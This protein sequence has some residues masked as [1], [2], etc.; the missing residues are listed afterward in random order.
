MHTQEKIS[1]ST[2][3][4]KGSCVETSFELN[5]SQYNAPINSSLKIQLQIQNCKQLFVCF[6]VSLEKFV[7]KFV[8]K[9]VGLRIFLHALEK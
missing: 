5:R 8:K 4:V 3:P 1:I 2:E 9:F 6:Q 7:E